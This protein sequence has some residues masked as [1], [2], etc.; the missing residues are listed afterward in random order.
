MIEK[1]SEDWIFEHNSKKDLIC[2]INKLKYFR[3][4]R[5]YGGHSGIDGDSFKVSI[6]ILNIDDLIRKLKIL[7]IV[8]KPV[9]KYSFKESG[10][11]NEIYSFPKYEQPSHQII[12][13]IAAFVWVH[14]DYFEV[15][16]SGAKDNNRFIVSEKDFENALKIEEIID[17][18]FLKN[19]LVEHDSV[20]YI[21]KYRYK[22]YFI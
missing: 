21:N 11:S 22:E 8:L 5:A 2:W 18:S 3:F 1:Y 19:F 14:D 16:L 9:D 7:D 20:L 15:S 12:F 4:F 13:N 10:R 6:R 17:N